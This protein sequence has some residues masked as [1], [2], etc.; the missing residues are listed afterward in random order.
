MNSLDVT[1]LYVVVEGSQV[2][3]KDGS[4]NK[5]MDDW[6]KKERKK[7]ARFC[8]DR[9]PGYTSQ[10]PLR[11]PLLWPTSIHYETLSE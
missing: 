3:V 2:V 4:L 1:G 7:D 10:A 8:V 5:P 11:E 9:P 6:I